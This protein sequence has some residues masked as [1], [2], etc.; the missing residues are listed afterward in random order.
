MKNLFFACVCI[1][2]LASC[3]FKNKETAFVEENIV[4]V[5]TQLRG[6]LTAVGEPTEKNYPRTHKADGTLH[7][8]NIYD[9]TP[10]FFPGS[11]WYLYELTEDAYWKQEAEKWTY[12]LERLKTFTGHHDIGFMMYCSYG[13]AERLA[14]QPNYKDIL[15]ESANSLCTRYNDTTQVIK[16]WNY[17]KAW[18]GSEWFYPVIIDNMMNLELLFFASRVTG[19]QKY[20]DVAV[21]H[22]NTTLANHFRD[23]FSSYHV[24][25]YDPKTGEPIHWQTCQGYS[26]NSTWSRGQ[27]WAVYGYTMMYRE[28]D[29][30]QYLVAAEK[31]ADYYLSHLPEDGIPYWD[32]NVGEEGYTPEGESYA[33]QSQEKVKDASA[34][35]I[36]CSALFELAELTEKSIYQEKAV[37]MLH[38][39]A[40]PAY[41]AELNENAHFLLKHCTGSYPHKTEIDVPLVYADY[42][43]LEALS[44]Y[45]KMLANK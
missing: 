12:P 20:Y 17:R 9:W 40:S 31:L 37:Q 14:S 42:Y 24:V 28:T 27:A 4:F 36:V 13:Q 33:V 26:D 38:T 22:A 32:F 21:T 8:T 29:D 39:L 25:N 43:F 1:A 35:A 45:K 5:D 10:G 7:T 41:R 16:S 3:Q 30:K 15:I 23:D 11:L 44:R 19:D 2:L 6:M 18:D 34:A